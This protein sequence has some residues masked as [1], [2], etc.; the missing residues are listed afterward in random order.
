MRGDESMDLL[1]DQ[2]SILPILG[3]TSWDD[4]EDA[5]RDALEMEKIVT[6]SIKSLVSLLMH[7]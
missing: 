3:K 2:G 1:G 6:G 4:G 7:A 5:L